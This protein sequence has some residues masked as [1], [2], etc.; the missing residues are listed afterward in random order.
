MS[1]KSKWMEMDVDENISQKTDNEKVNGSIVDTR[2]PG[3][4]EDVTETVRDED[5]TVLNVMNT[6]GFRRCGKEMVDYIA[7]YIDTVGSRN[8]NPSV[9]PG[10]MK[11]LVPSTAPETGEKWEDVISDIERVIMPGMLHWHSP[12][13]HGY[14]TAGS[15]FPSICAD[16]LS[17][18]FGCIGFSWAASPACTE[19]E[20]IVTDWLAKMLHLPDVFMSTGKGGGVIQGATS[21]STFL[22]LLAARNKTMNKLRGEM[23]DTSDDAI[24]SKLVAYCS[25]QAH[26]SVER[27]C[28]LAAVQLVKVFTDDNESMRGERL[29]DAIQADRAKGLIPFYVCGTLGTTSSCAFDNLAEIGPVCTKYDIWLHIDA[30]FAGSAFI[31][32]EYRHHLNGVEHAMTFSF[33]PHKWLLTNFDCATMWIQDSAYLVDAFR[34]HHAPYMEHHFEQEGPD[35]MNWDIP[36]GRRFR[37]LKLWFVMRMYGVKGLQKYIRR[38]V[39]LGNYFTDLVRSDDR[40]EL[41]KPINMSVVCFRL[42]GSNALNQ[43]LTQHIRLDGRIHISPSVIKGQFLPRFVPGTW[44]TTEADVLFAWNVITEI[45]NKLLSQS[46]N[47][48]MENGHQ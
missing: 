36:M 43:E 22:A 47:E 11:R 28:R 21:S 48:K 8:V 35:F 1:M 33:N 9:E 32:P 26:M 42:K 3:S 14:V 37:A 27:A 23:A 38:H 39:R 45:A 34:A 46:A 25:R 29:S 6:D 19:L 20:V 4:I 40:F 41:P 7:D 16:M 15:S 31:C 30:A 17:D 44:K 2:V 5:N 24:M 18:A 12:H 10:Y 13:F